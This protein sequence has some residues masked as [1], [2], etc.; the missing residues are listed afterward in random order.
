MQTFLP[1]PDLWMSACCLD[2]RRL[3]KQRVECKQI[4]LALGV[5]VGDHPGDEGS[6]WRNHPAVRMWR[7]HEHYLCAYSIYACCEWKRRGFHDSLLPQFREA[8]SV[9]GSTPYPDW[10]GLDK[11]HASHRSNLLRKMPQYYG[12]YGWSEPPDMPYFW[13][14]CRSVAVTTTA[15]GGGSSGR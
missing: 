10:M 6:A 13:P 4:L 1:W 8:Q 2:S 3:G 15:E 12:V 5:P 11:L 9:I 7:G 14:V